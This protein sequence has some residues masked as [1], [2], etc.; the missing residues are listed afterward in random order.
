MRRC[1]SAVLLA[2]AISSVA[3]YAQH[4]PPGEL[5]PSPP[6]QPGQL[7]P[8]PAKSAP[9][10]ST[11]SS[12]QNQNVAVP[13]TAADNYTVRVPVTNI[14]VP[15]TVFDPD[16]HGYVNG[17]TARDFA[18]LDNDKPQKITS[19]L[20]E[21][22]LSL[23]LAVQANAEVDP[24]LPVIRKSGLL[25][26][27]LVTGQDG[28]VAILAFDHRMQLIQDFTREPDKLD[29]AMQKITA[30]S[31][32]A[33]LVDAVGEADHLLKR[34]D[35]NNARRRVIILM[36]RNIDKG[37]ESKLQETVRDMQF[38][39]VIVYCVDISRVKTALL[40]KPDYPG[41]QNG[42]VPPEALPTVTGQTRTETQVVQQENGNA[43]NTLP[44]IYRGIRDLF[45]KTPAEAFTYFT[46]GNL[47]SFSNQRGLEDAI[48][49]IG[50]D[51]NSQYLLSYNPNNKEEPG[52]HNIK[53]VVDR[54]G[55]RV[56]TRPGYWWGG[57]QQ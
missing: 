9:N 42:R 5:P 54:P 43:L 13:A 4:L 28:D 52:F 6:P 16:G 40:K 55:L 15:T 8:A 30:G 39:N 18:V 27:G 31:S 51:L 45:K 19:E 10:Q 26:H 44:P 35:P 29:D 56:R 1:S 41:P 46:G 2:L 25:L 7:G 21:Q 50:K 22:P 24:L 48:A 57:G 12:S 11:P 14:L 47:Y 36:S 34:H 37:S 49:D 32:S 3:A 23:V 20:T 33:R 38:D 17:L 53:V